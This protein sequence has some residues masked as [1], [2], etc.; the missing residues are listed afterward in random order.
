MHIL[1][2]RD[3]N[4]FIFLQFINFLEFNLSKKSEEMSVLSLLNRR[5]N[6]T[7]ICLGSTYYHI[8]PNTMHTFIFQNC[9][10]N[11]CMGIILE[12]MIWVAQSAMQ[13]VV[14]DLAKCL[15]KCLYYHCSIPG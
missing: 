14:T 5:L 8:Y 9:C 1:F 6:F 11:N 3:M 4:S 13:G 2:T 15:K 7:K 12:D 10:I